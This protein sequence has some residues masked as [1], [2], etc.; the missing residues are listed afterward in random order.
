MTA[1]SRYWRVVT[2]CT[3]LCAWPVLAGNNTNDGPL[4]GLDDLIKR[5]G[6]ENVPTGINVVVGQVEA[7][8]GN[9]NFYPNQGHAEFVGKMFTEMS[10]ISANPSGHATNVGKNFYGLSTSVAPGINDIYLW[11]ANNW[12]ISGF[13]KMN[14][15]DTTPPAD[16]PE[17]LKLFNHSWVGSGGNAFDNTA[18]RRADFVAIRDD[19]L[20]MVGV[21]NGGASF[22]LLSHNYNGLSVGKM[23]GGHTSNSTVA[24]I[25][26]PGRQKPDIVAPGSA[27]S[28]STPVLG[29][30]A[31]MMIETA[32]TYEGLSSNPNAERSEVIKAVLLAGAAKTNAHGPDWTNNAIASGP[33]RGRTTSPL[34]DVIGA[35]TVNVNNSH[36]ILTGIEQDGSANPPISPNIEY[37]GW[38]LTSVELGESRYYR[39]RVYEL[40]DA[41]SILVTWH[42]QVSLG[43]DNEDWATA[44]FKLVLWRVDINGD[45]VTLLG[46]PG[47]DYFEGGNIVSESSVDNIEHLYITGLAAGDYTLELSRDDDLLDYPIWDAA[48]AWQTPSPP[49]N[50]ADLNGDGIVNTSD[51]L[52]LLANWGKCVECILPG[53][54]LGDYNDDCIVNISDLLFLLLNW[55]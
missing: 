36:M 47:L 35:G 16:V 52:I 40:A 25:D 13:L 29:A 54:C 1:I 33:N 8:N 22:P 31:A 32:R 10:A 27:T 21:N 45:L 6:K 41:L 12:F 34:D 43:F 53:D 50:P 23:D 44:D 9:G 15:H 39:F 24:G 7:P 28:W 2:A 3:L 49:A 14:A 42:R 46:D 5:I 37:T 48:L 38:D 51:I 55:W 4:I 26:G 20:M 11:E 17:G 30:A 19:L 18:L